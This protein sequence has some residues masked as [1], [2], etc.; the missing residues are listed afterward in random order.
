MWQHIGFQLPVCRTLPRVRVRGSQLALLPSIAMEGCVGMCSYRGTWRSWAEQRRRRGQGE[1]RQRQTPLERMKPRL[2][3]LPVCSGAGVGMGEHI[4]D[5]VPKS[6]CTCIIALAAQASLPG[7]YAGQ[8]QGRGQGEARQRRRASAAPP[9]RRPGGASG[10]AGA[11]PA[12]A[13]KPCSHPVRAAAALTRWS[14]RRSRQ[15]RHPYQNPV[16]T[17]S[18]APCSSACERLPNVPLQQTST[19]LADL[20]QG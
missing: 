14:F 5:W 4:S 20:N 18:D 19:L 9:Q 3:G 1:A 13:P 10:G 6:A 15:P 11:A 2:Q 12:P 16:H 17:L 8:R 7:L